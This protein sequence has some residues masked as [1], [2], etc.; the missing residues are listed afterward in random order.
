[1]I[2]GW[3][4]LFIT[5]QD[6]STI[7]KSEVDCSKDEGGEALGNDKS[8]NAIKT[9]VD[10]IIFKL[11]TL[12]LKLKKLGRCGPYCSFNCKFFG[13]FTYKFNYPLWFELIIRNDKK[14]I[15]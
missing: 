4:N 13:G 14:N 9:S 10:K 12:I 6:C 5:S 3:K 7:V 11:T 8:L 15:R 2:G 1:M